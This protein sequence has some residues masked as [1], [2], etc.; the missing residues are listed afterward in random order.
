[1]EQ[2]VGEKGHVC[3]DCS[4][5]SFDAFETE[6]ALGS[7]LKVFLECSDCEAEDDLCLSPAEAKRCDF[8]PHAN[9]PD[10]P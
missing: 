1:V 3:R 9:L 2:V 8:D 6:W 5:T 4:S 10:V 7:K